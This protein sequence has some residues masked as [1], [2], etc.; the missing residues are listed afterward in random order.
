ML[1]HRKE[2]EVMQNKATIYS[3]LEQAHGLLNPIT[4]DPNTI[5][6]SECELLDRVR[7][8]LFV[9]VKAMQLA[10]MAEKQKPH[11]GVLLGRCPV[12]G[13]YG[14]DCKGTKGEK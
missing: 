1:L 13:H 3:L 4:Y 10:E 7:E 6:P 14:D 9:I 8:A 11:R 12:C 5:T 2:K